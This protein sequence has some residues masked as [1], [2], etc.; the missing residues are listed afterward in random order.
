MQAQTGSNAAEEA[1]GFSAGEAEE[2]GV[3]VAAGGAIGVASIRWRTAV[4]VLGWLAGARLPR[5][6]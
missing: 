1:R 2:G 6:C 4:G 3:E 5:L